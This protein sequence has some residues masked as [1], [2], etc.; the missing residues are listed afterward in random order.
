M[1]STYHTSPSL[2]PHSHPGRQQRWAPSHP[3]I[4]HTICKRRCWNSYSRPYDSKAIFPH[5]PRDVGCQ[6]EAPQEALAGK[7][8]H[9]LESSQLFP[10]PI[11]EQN[12]CQGEPVVCRFTGEELSDA[13]I[14]AY[15]EM[16]FSG[17]QSCAGPGRGSIG[18]GRLAST[19]SSICPWVSFPKSHVPHPDRLLS[20]VPMMHNETTRPHSQKLFFLEFLSRHSKNESD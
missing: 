12:I 19:M 20:C 14:S 18:S 1:P 8:V 15:I 10:E 11:N 2:C 13:A 9:A 5:P 6:G 3:I 4:C 7:W 17:R 16:A